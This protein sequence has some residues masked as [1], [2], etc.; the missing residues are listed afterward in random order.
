MGIEA[1]GAG[2]KAPEEFYVVIEIP[3][4]G[5][6][7]KYEVDKDTGLLM[8]DRFMNVAMCYPANYG[9]VPKTLGGDGDPV[10]VLV[11]TPHP[12]VAGSIIKC[13]AVA[14]LD[15]TDEKGSDAKLLAVPT[16]KVSNGAYDHLHDLADVPERTKNEIQHFY[17]RYKDLEKGK[18]VKVAGWRDAAAARAEIEAGIKA[19][20]G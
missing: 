11:M 1:L 5:P 4:Y 8:V 9:Y 2:D 3:A 12:V 6:P 16:D 19:Y 10:D 20:K 13:R 14:V 15:T 18:W 17:E 7:V